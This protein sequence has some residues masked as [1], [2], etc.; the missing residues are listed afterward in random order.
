MAQ[1]SEG[2]D[3]QPSLCVCYL[4]YGGI[5]QHGGTMPDSRWQYTIWKRL[6]CIQ[7]ACSN[8]LETLAMQPL[9]SP[10]SGCA[11]CEVILVHVIILFFCV[12]STV[13]A[14]N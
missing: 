2:L 12:Y 13:K 3:R 1:F 5:G 14:L 6:L 7:V 11:A 8:L 10:E 9:Q 4:A